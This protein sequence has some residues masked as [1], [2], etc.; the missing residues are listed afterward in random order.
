[1]LSLER[2]RVLHAIASY[3]SVR[4]AADA[5]QVTTSAVSLQIAKLED[6]LDQRLLDRRGRGVQLTDAANRL[7]QHA[8]RILSVVAEAEA[9]LEARR[10]A[11]DGP[12]SVAAFASAARGLL[13][14][15]LVAL[16]ASH[17]DVRASLSVIEPEEGVPLVS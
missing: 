17:P 12:L 5:L 3:G 9:D 13:P 10:G 4:G 6:E 11:V 2:L 15:A 1:M 16:R 14:D 7:V 8:E